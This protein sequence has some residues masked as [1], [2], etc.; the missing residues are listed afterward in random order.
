MILDGTER[1]KLNDMR[2]PVSILK[3]KVGF[4]GLM[5]LEEKEGKSTL[6]PGQEGKCSFPHFSAIQSLLCTPEFTLNTSD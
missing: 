4:I 6:F 3:G 2:L 1:P 5:L